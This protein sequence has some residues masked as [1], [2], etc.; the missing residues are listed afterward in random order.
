M[1]TYI[2]TR[3]S[4]GT[5]FFTLVVADRRNGA[6]LTENADSLREAFRRVRRTHPFTL[7]AAVVLPDHV[8]CLWT[9]PPGDL[10]V[11]VSSAVAIEVS[12]LSDVRM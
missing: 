11:S 12:C 8:H 7:D 6:L 2:R 1:R 3:I 9:L 10:D 5:Y 4:G